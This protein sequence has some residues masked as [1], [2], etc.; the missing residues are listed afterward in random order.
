MKS[1]AVGRALVVAIAC[2]RVPKTSVL[3]GL[4]KPMWLS[5]ICTKLKSPTGFCAAAAVTG[6]NIFELSTPPLAVHNIPVPAQAMHFR[7]PRRSTPSC[8]ALW[9]MGSAFAD[10]RRTSVTLLGLIF[11]SFEFVCC[12]DCARRKFIPG[13]KNVISELNF[14]EVQASHFMVVFIPDTFV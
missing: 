5:L 3:A 1:G 9:L 11:I 7:K 2:L 8:P 14:S 13:N 6:L 12:P 4:L 10:R